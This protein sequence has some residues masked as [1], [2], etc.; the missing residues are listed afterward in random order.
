[1]R[2]LSK[3]PTSTIVLHRLLAYICTKQSDYLEINGDEDIRFYQAKEL[4]MRKP[5]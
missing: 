2:R 4:S 1:M 3:I 5:K